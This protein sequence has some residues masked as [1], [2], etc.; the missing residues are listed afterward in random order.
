MNK[1]AETT[2]DAACAAEQELE[3]KMRQSEANRSTR[4]CASMTK[5]LFLF[6]GALA[7]LSSGS[8]YADKASFPCDA[9][10]MKSDGRLVAV[11]SVLIKTGNGSIQMNPGTSFGPGVRMA[12]IDLYNTYQENC[13]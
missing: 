1:A 6:A 10:Q 11:K 8:T 3:D 4:R 13:H 2:L 7:L 12:G 5:T 9:F